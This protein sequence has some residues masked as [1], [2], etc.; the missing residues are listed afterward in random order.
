MGKPTKADLTAQA[1]ALGIDVPTQANMAVIRALIAEAEEA[2]AAAEP[3]DM[4]DI[5]EVVPDEVPVRLVYSGRKRHEA[6]F[7]I[8]SPTHVRPDD[9]EV[10]DPVVG[11]G[12][13]KDGDTVPSTL[14][15]TFDDDG[16]AEVTEAEWLA[17]RD[18]AGNL[19][20]SRIN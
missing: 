13:N 15:V 17:M 11:G 9:A 10:T 6:Y 14:R 16:Y 2:L 1:E 4:I 7:P 3:V 20:I 5:G 8:P 19:G 18:Y 12:I